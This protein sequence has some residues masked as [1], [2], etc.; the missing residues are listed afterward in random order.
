MRAQEPLFN[1]SHAPVRIAAAGAPPSPPL[2][3]HG[4]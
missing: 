1:L 2:V 4:G 3:M